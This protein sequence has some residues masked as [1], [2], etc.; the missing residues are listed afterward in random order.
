MCPASRTRRTIAVMK[1][2]RGFYTPMITPF[3]ASGAVDLG[4]LQDN[5]ARWM[6]TSLDGIVVLGSNGEA[7]QLEDDEADR[8]ILAVRIRVPPGKMLIAGTGRESTRATIA[9]TARAAALGAD[10]VLVR[11]PSFFKTQMTT[12]V[13][14]RHYKE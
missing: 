8:M 13:L 2:F 4:A 1:R 11:T 12:D 3:D 6:A 10:A 9:A 5:V 7:A 14:V